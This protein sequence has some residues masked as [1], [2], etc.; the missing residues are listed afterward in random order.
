MIRSDLDCVCFD[1]GLFLRIYFWE[2]E[3]TMESVANKD[4]AEKC[5][6]LAKS[7]LK[8]GQYEKAIK[9]F[10]KSLRL[11]PLPGV[12]ALR[13]RAIE[14]LKNA[15][16]SSHNNNGRSKNSGR[17]PQTEE[18]S[19]VKDS[20]KRPYTNEQEALA[21]KILNEAKKG[22]YDALGVSKGAS[23][24]DIKKAYRKL[25]LKLHPDKNSAPSAEGAFKAISSAFDTLSD[26]QK[27]QQY[28]DYGIDDNSGPAGGGGGPFHT[29]Q[30]HP[31]D[32]L[33]ML[34]NGG[35]RQ[36]RGGGGG[37]HTFHFGGGPPRRQQREDN[38]A[39]G[40]GGNPF[41]QLLQFLPVL[42]FLFLT[43]GSMGGSGGG[44]SRSGGA[45]DRG[46]LPYSFVKDNR[47]RI[48]KETTLLGEHVNIPYY[49]PENF[50]L[51][52]A[53]TLNDLREVERKVYLE[54]R[55]ILHRTCEAEKE[56]KRRAVEKF[57]KKR[58][59]S[60]ATKAKEEKKLAEMK[61][62]SCDQYHE[63][64]GRDASNRWR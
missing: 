41:A 23:E 48:L 8:S 19:S 21:K 33:D 25:A 39:Q 18:G 28:D 35:M 20:S 63:I 56:T 3:V 51:R 40:N 45:Y 11:H 10:D 13:A 26:P 38:N 64:Y 55:D 53:R 49:V 6:D 29:Q 1:P 59:S 50:A 30:M 9:F 52:Y 16:S 7:F 47:F 60:S 57:K 2:V 42:L 12:E 58:F 17:M 27:K 32:F 46:H 22:H 31:E 44:M 15:Q 43:M 34:F 4:E 61:A 5:R 62:P 36:R 14:S 24:N 37:F 54:Y